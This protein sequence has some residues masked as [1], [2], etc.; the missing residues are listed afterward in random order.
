VPHGRHEH[1]GQQRRIGDLLDRTGIVQQIK[2]EPGEGGDDD[3]PDLPQLLL[4]GGQDP[5][6]EEQ[7]ETDRDEMERDRIPG[8]PDRDR[9]EVQ[10]AEA[11][12]HHVQPPAPDPVTAVARNLVNRQ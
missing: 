8:W 2:A 12:P 4:V 11:Y 10:Q 9:G 5:E 1:R 6:P 3:N 7:R